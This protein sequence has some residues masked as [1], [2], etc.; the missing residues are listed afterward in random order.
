MLTLVITQPTKA[1]VHGI[2]AFRLDF[3]V[4]DY[5]C[6]GIVCLDGSWGLCAAHLIED[7]LNVDSLTGHDVKGSQ[8][9]TSG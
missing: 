4:D 8:F 1:D 3:S 5:I 6:N 9:G 7:D 2:C